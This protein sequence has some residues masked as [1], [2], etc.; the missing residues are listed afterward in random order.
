MKTIITIPHTKKTVLFKRILFTII[1][2][3]TFHFR[4]RKRLLLFNGVLLAQDIPKELILLCMDYDIKV[5][6]N[7]T[8]KPRGVISN[9]TV[10]GPSS[11]V[12]IPFYIK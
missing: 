12:A 4:G 6:S 9:F 5:I 1:F 3:F 11:P 8:V 10:C 7:I 2:Q